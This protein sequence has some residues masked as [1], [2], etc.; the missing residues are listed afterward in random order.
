MFARLFGL[1]TSEPE[2]VGPHRLRFVDTGGASVELVESLS[3]DS[4]V[5]KFLSSRGP[6]LHHICLRVRDIEAALAALQAQGVRL[7][8][9]QPRAGAAGARIAFI[10]PSSTQGLLIEI[11]EL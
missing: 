6:G 4:P 11:K 2:T 7:I 9:T 3:P 8:D 1:T 5:A 10:H